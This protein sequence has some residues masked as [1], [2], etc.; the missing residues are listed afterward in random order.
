MH[1]KEPVVLRVLISEPE[2][3]QGSWEMANIDADCLG[4]PSRPPAPLLMRTGGRAWLAALISVSFWIR[5]MEHCSA[6]CCGTCFFLKRRTNKQEKSKRHSASAG[7]L[8]FTG[9]CPLAWVLAFSFRDCWLR[10]SQ[11][12][13]KWC[14]SLRIWTYPGL[15][16]AL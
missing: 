11:T 4:S 10:K 1:S 3:G 6:G 5:L 15:I 16:L 9:C 8:P 7:Y 2:G 12:S 13:R 14:G